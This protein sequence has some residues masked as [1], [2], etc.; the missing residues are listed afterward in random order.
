MLMIFVKCNRCGSYV[1]INPYIS[2]KYWCS[3]IKIKD[4]DKRE[5]AHA[6]DLCS[7]CTE[8]LRH[9]IEKS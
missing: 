8:D 2:G 9:W 5:M 6:Y 7:D 3:T 1:P 4:A